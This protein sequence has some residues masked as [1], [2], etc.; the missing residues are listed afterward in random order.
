MKVAVTSQGMT[1]DSKTDM[2]LG[3]ASYFMVFDDERKQWECVS[4]QQNLEAAQGAGIQAAQ[5]V[6]KL[7]AT[8]L[9]TGNVGPKAFKVLKASNVK[10]F[11]TKDLTVQEAYN[12]YI[13]QQLAELTE[14]N[15]EGHWS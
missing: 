3:R 7:G 15:V 14:A 5:S 6:R 1:P 10:M 11:T 4:N 2:R 12:A 13:Q 9:I 8:V